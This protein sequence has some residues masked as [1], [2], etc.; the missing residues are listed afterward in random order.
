M[1]MK[2]LMGAVLMLGLAA[3]N[4]GGGL[5]I[6]QGFNIDANLTGASV[7]TA[8]TQVVDS[9]TGAVK[10]YESTYTLTQPNAIFNVGPQS[11]GMTLQGFTVEVLDN[12]G[13]RYGDDQGKYQRSVSYV[14]QP[15]FICSTA[16]TTLDNCAPSAKVASKVATTIGSLPLVTDRIAAL[17]VND[18]E[19]TG[20]PTLKLKVT[21]SGTDD[22]GRAQTLTVVSADLAS[23]VSSFSTI[24]E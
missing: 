6:G 3:C 14:V 21:F 4:S 11:V 23:S 24:K 20:C 2:A 5:N 8:I 17:I 13:T 19:T 15:G 16:G 1:K 10:R 18:C 9:T 12:A 7:R 22:A